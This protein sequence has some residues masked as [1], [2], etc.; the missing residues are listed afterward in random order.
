MDWIQAVC[1][2]RLDSEPMCFLGSSTAYV[3]I[4]T[5]MP[6][7]PLFLFLT[8]AP[9]ILPIYVNFCWFIS[10]YGGFLRSYLDFIRNEFV[11]IH[12]I[13]KRGTA[14]KT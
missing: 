7:V 10:L 12:D 6:L 5:F 4:D 14:F 1:I 13:W 2:P 8:K 3:N 9:Q 11:L